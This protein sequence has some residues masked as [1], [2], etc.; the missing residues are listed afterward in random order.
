VANLDRLASLP[1]LQRRERAEQGPQTR[2]IQKRIHSAN[3]PCAYMN[4]EAGPEYNI[5][6]EF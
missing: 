2:P 1:A 6:L 4:N 5:K 3:I